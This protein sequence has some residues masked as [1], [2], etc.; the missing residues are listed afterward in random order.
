[1]VTILK[2]AQITEEE[3]IRELKEQV[4]YKYFSVNT[5]SGDSRVRI[6]SSLDIKDDRMGYLFGIIMN[7]YNKYANRDNLMQIFAKE[8]WTVLNSYEPEKNKFPNLKEFYKEII[9]AEITYKKEKPVAKKGPEKYFFT[10]LN[11]TVP[12]KVGD[13]VKK[14]TITT[15]YTTIEGKTVAYYLVHSKDSINKEKYPFGGDGSTIEDHLVEEDSLLHSKRDT[16]Y[17]TYYYKWF[18]ENKE[19]ILLDSQE[20]FIKSLEKLDKN[21]DLGDYSRKGFKEITGYDGRTK[22]RTYRRI[23]NRVRKA[24]DKKKPN[25]LTRKQLYD[26][27]YLKYYKK[28]MVILDDDTDL[29]NQNLKLTE[30]LAKGMKSEPFGDRLTEE[31]HSNLE[32][33]D[34]IKLNRFIKGKHNNSLNCKSLYSI[35][36]YFEKQIHIT[37]KELINSREPK[38]K[39]T[40]TQEDKV[41]NI[42]NSLEKGETEVYSSSPVITYNKEGEQINIEK[43]LINKVPQYE[44]VF[45]ILPGGLLQQS[46]E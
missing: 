24:W 15:K 9:K 13:I 46:K 4:F 25:Y 41:L 16:Y 34:K 20:G 10:Y 7:K 23:V 6:S 45:K 22:Q 26:E 38:R 12:Y 3:E 42:I 8:V 30:L 31:I 5:I 1:M 36:Q 40:I 32:T 11:R 28:F 19:K 21:K 33:E 29:S 39:D 18:Q 35:A 44:K 43:Y 37:E 27:P 2:D 14:D 17:K